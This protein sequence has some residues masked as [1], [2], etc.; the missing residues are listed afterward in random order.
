MTATV[1]SKVP[2]QTRSWLDRNIFE[3]IQIN[4]ET[5]TFAAILILA[6]VTRFYDLGTRVMS[7][8]ESLHT[9]FS[10]LLYR[11]EGFQHTPLMHGPFQFHM[12]AL[13]YFLFG[14]SDFTAR[15]PA[16]LF[17]IAAIVF[18]WQYRRYL[19]RAGAL[20][21]AGLF[22]F[23][24]YL[25]YYSRY[26]R[27]EAF[28]ILFFVVTLWATVR[29]LETG[30]GRYLIYFTIVN[31]LHFTTKE[32][33]FIYLAQ[34]MLFL[35]LVFLRQ[36]YTRPWRKPDMRRLFTVF[37]AL[38]VLLM[39]AAVVVPKILN[40]TA[41]V[42]VE[43]DTPAPQPAPG[44]EAEESEGMNLPGYEVAL[45]ALGGLSLLGALIIAMQGYGMDNLKRLRSFSMLL[46]NLTIILPH[47]AAF[48]MRALG[49][50]PLDYAT[51]EAIIRIAIFVVPLIAISAAVGF[52]WNPRAWLINNAIFYG[53]FVVFLTTMFTNGAGVFSGLV[54]SLGYWLVQQGVRRGSQPI[55]YYF[56][57]QVPIYEYL[58]ALGSLLAAGLG[59]KGLIDFW[60]SKT[61][62]SPPPEDVDAYLL[63]ED[64]KTP[65]QKTGQKLMLL[66]LGFWTI[67]AFLAYTLAG[68]KM[69]WLTVHLALPMALLTG[70]ALG[71]LVGQVNWPD[72]WS[73]RGWLASLVLVVLL[74]AVGGLLSSLFN[75][76]RPFSGKELVQLEAT[77]TFLFAGLS[78][79][80]ALAAL[81]YV[82]KEWNVNQ[83]VM[84]TALTLFALLGISTARH[85]MM[86][87]YINY[88]DATE[89]LVYAHAARGVK[90][91]MAQVED[92]SRRTT[93]GLAIRVAYDNDVSW[94]M[95]WYLRNYP[96]RVYYGESPNRDL[97]SAPMIIVGDNNFAAMESIVGQGY[98][99]FDYIR[100]WWPNQDYF[101]LTWEKVR[102]AFTNPAIRAGMMDIWFNRDYSTYAQALN[103]TDMTLWDWNPSDRMRLYI[104]KD[105]VASLYDYGVT[106]GSAA[107]LV[108]D[109]YEGKRL[110][111]EADQVLFPLDENG[112][113][114]NAPR[115]MAVGPDGALFV[116]DS[117]N[118]RVVVIENGQIT[119]TIGGPN[120]GT[121]PGEFNEPWGVAVS[122]DG[123][124]IYV[125]DTWNHR[126]QVF[127]RS[128]EFLGSWGQFATDEDPYSLWGPRDIAVD[129]DG[130]LLVTN[131]G[132]KRINRYTPDGE[133]LG[134]FGEFGFEAGQLDE[135]VGIA[136]S[137]SGRVYVA[138]TWNQRMQAFDIGSDGEYHPVTEWD[139][140]GWYSDSL[141]NKPFVGVGDA[142]VVLVTD[143]EASRILVFNPD[144]QFLFYIG[145]VDVSDPIRL[146]S[147]VAGDG[148]GGIWVV[149]GT[150]NR[151]MHFQP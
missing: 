140:N 60:N 122:A 108:I 45:L 75:E 71:W 88:D 123:E 70:W 19:G 83:A 128:G 137:E 138:D 119:L 31:A 68:E 102:D 114:L 26:V 149:D 27:N 103:R 1:E 9:Y 13:S 135:P 46:L 37:L 67:T 132:N 8:D 28:I 95:T 77:S 91:V 141:Q 7:H 54:G 66:L 146:A 38:T 125:A 10:W 136:V 97:R 49:W 53:I 89:Y 42:A 6:V 145:E 117:Q 90:E 23:S 127:T 142:G 106:E 33:S 100:M 105:V 96:N 85:A 143:P 92:I 58:A 62:Q 34:V 86:A 133:A 72:F 150:N 43:A 32:T 21:A 40:S 131:T 29:Y 115:G 35:G 87:S 51:T 148:Q 73:K 113:G 61:P 110:D 107:E 112:L 12:L 64:A 79:A 81:W 20:V 121:G 24:P 109:P 65:D 18:L 94:P 22:T 134:Y 44:D 101:G 118:H 69:P 111:I 99:R 120:P 147:G 41:N 80:G 52:W 59:L 116:A 14:D 4:W 151:L 129:G 124:Q 84:A 17:S 2:S 78:T 76:P 57:I 93:D 15:I 16:V 48:P 56:M 50:D 98:E 126:V 11:G 74:F 5:L 47:L 55:Y 144:G 104:R 39:T 3:S 139:I 30:Q 82:F 36:I 130:N 25:L 63:E